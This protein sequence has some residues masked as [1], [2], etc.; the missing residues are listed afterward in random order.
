MWFEIFKASRWNNPF[1]DAISLL[2]AFSRFRNRTKVK[3]SVG[4]VA[5]SSFWYLDIKTYKIICNFKT[6]L[7]RSPEICKY[8][9]VGKVE[10]INLHLLSCLGKL[11]ASFQNIFTI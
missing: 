9:V 4:Y 3:I 5:I 11:E 8:L 7:S 1:K 6:G 2:P 10:L